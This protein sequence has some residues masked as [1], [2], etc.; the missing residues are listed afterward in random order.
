MDLSGTGDSESKPAATN[1][2]KIRT[3]RLLIRAC[4]GG[5]RTSVLV[6]HPLPC[7]L[8]EVRE[9]IG[10]RSEPFFTFVS[11]PFFNLLALKHSEFFQKAVAV[12]SLT[13][14][15]CSFSGRPKSLWFLS[16]DQTSCT[17]IRSCPAQVLETSFLFVKL[18]CSLKDVSV[19]D[20]IRTFF[21][22][23]TNR[24]QESRIRQ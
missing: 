7:R 17:S 12:W 20:G 6:Y 16:G 2:S 1:G 21:S 19:K 18:F 8:D 13:Q 15:M 9:G 24:D 3:W 4:A 23:K 11:P 22:M 5:K 10:V 14:E